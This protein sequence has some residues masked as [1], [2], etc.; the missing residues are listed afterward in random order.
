[1]IQKTGKLSHALGL[2][3]LKWLEWLYYP[4]AIHISNLIAIKLPKTF[5]TEQE[6]IVL[7]FIWNHKRFRI[8]KALLGKKNKAG[9]ITFLDF[10]SVQ[11]L[12][13]V[14]LFATP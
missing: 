8:A 4:S 5:Y 9:G 10:S 1:M 13:H 11:S 2:E 6:Q 3:E 7:K 14:Q 12:S